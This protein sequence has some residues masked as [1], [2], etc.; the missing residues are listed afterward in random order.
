[1]SH[2]PNAIITEEDIIRRV[3]IVLEDNSMGSGLSQVRN[4][5]L[6]LNY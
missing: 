5:E 6:I 1:M 4:K 3:G 2:H